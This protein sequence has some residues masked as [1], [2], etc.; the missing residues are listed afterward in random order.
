MSRFN[1]R[2][3]LAPKE[4]LLRVVAILASIVILASAMPKNTVNELTY[5]KGE[6][7]DDSP[8]IA[9]DS[10]PVFKPEMVLERERD[11]LHR[12]YEPYFLQDPAVRDSQAAA[13]NSDFRQLPKNAVPHYYLAHL[14]KKLAEVY[15]R[16]VMET[17]DH[18]RLQQE[19]TATIRVFWQNEASARAFKQVFTEKTAYEYMMA[20]EDSTAFS[21]KALARCDLARYIHPNLTYDVTKS[22]QQRQEVDNMLVP[23]MGQVQVGQKIVDRGQIVDDYTFCVLKSLERHQKER[24]KSTAE[25]VTLTI[26]QILYAT[27]MVLMLFGYFQQ[28]RSDYLDSMRTVALV[29]SLSLVFPLATYGMVEHS[30]MSVYVIPYCILPIFIRIFMD[31]RTAFITHVITLLICAEALKHPFEFMVTETLAGL[32]AIYSLRQLSQRSD[33]LRAAI[34]V[35]AVSLLSYLCIDVMHGNLSS[36]DGLDKWTYIYLTIAGILSMISYLLLIPVERIFGF[37][38]NV[39]LVELSNINSTVLRRLSEEAPGTF[40]HSMQVANLATEVANNLMAKSQLVRTGALYHDIGKLRNPVFFTENQS[41]V[42]PHEGMALEK[43]AQ[44]I[45]RHVADGMRLA[46]KYKLPKAVKDFIATHH[47]TSMAKYFY[48]SY[49]NKYPDREPDPSL[50]TYPGP[51]PSTLE[52]AILMMADAVEAASRSLPQYTEESVSALVEKII[53]GQVKDGYFK[54]CPITFRE[55][56]IAKDVFKSKL[57][58]I[59]HTRVQYPDEQQKPEEPMQEA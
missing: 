2:R 17:E 38:S 34:A 19:G 14:Q 49:K 13:F 10:F 40:Q 4:I 30:L 37:T 24:E 46:D 12:F 16:G 18:D 53:D 7:W 42:N 26:G 27:L 58:T 48:I 59:Y 5:K 54:M 25:R 31:S 22:Q 50:F 41:G 6:P 33:L 23:Y 43:S 51:N 52:Q 39:T 3:R 47:G 36:T 56:E 55:I 1:H 32:V 29:A 9:T 21:Y 20:E 28:F 11:S 8:L 44:I 15:Q 57:K 45:I 35:T